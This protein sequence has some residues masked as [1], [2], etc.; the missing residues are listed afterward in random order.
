MLEEDIKNIYKEFNF[1]KKMLPLTKKEQSEFENTK[2]CWICQK[3]FE[4][5]DKKVRDHCHFTG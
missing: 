2:I 1:A 5:K 4:K 3:G